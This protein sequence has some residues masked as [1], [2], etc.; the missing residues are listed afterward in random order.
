MDLLFRIASDRA[1]V[2]FHGPRSRED[3]SA[4]GRAAPGCVVVEPLRAGALVEPTFSVGGAADAGPPRLF[5]NTD[6]DVSVVRLDGSGR[7]HLS[8]GDPLVL[9]R[10]R[11]VGPSGDAHGTVNFGSAVGPSRFKVHTEL[12]PEFEFTLKVFP[13]KLDFEDDR[14]RMIEEI[15]RAL[16]AAAMRWAGPTHGWGDLTTSKSTGLER[17]LIV[18][19][20]IPLLERGLAEVTRHPRRAIVR[21]PQP[22]LIHRVKRVDT[23]V[24]RDIRA[25][26]PGAQMEPLPMGA[27]VPRSVHVRTS[28][29]TVDTPEHRWFAQRLRLVA[30][31][32]A[33]LREAEAQ[34]ANANGE[35]AERAKLADGDLGRLA[36]RIDRLRRLEPLAAAGGPPPPG[37]ASLQLMT[38][39]GYGLAYYACMLLDLG[40]RIQNGVVQLAERGMDALYEYW[41]FLKVAAEVSEVA[42]GDP[43]LAPLFRV[44]AKGLAVGLAGGDAS[45]I[46]V[47][48]SA[49]TK[50]TITYQPKFDDPMLTLLGQEPDVLITHEERGWPEQWLVLDAKYRIDSSARHRERVGAPAPPAEALNVLYRYRDALLDG[51]GR[52]GGPATHVVVEAA[53]AYPHYPEPADDFQN[54]R[55]WASLERIGVGGIPLLPG[56]DAWLKEWLRR[57]L[58][59]G[60]WSLAERALAH[61]SAEA[62]QAQLDRLHQ[63]A[64]VCVV[65][66]ETAPARI[67]WHR[68]ALRF[69]LPRAALG[70]AK[71]VRWLAL[72]APAAEG[73]RGVVRWVAPVLH[74]E[75][76]RRGDL[77]TPWAATRDADELGLLFTLGEFRALERPI[78]NPDGERPPT[79]RWSTYLAL[80]H[81]RT[82]GELSIET[83]DEWRLQQR[84]LAEGIDYVVERHTGAAPLG[85]AGGRGGALFTFDDRI[86]VWHIASRGFEMAWGDGR[87]AA[88]LTVDGVVSRLRSRVS[89]VAS[90][91]P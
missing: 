25:S 29:P 55:L 32:L 78:E 60:A 19:H 83:I 71:F 13:T 23:S 88:A 41:V 79:Y 5:E 56:R 7:V 70:P 20:A 42:G 46:R 35:V 77:A 69:F 80:T 26:R 82:L 47:K 18:Q 57:T 31:M 6:Y 3:V 43:D 22:V 2:E 4:Y 16:G 12:G 24:L 39:A 67:D 89:A 49:G 84:L 87:S 27:R 30:G 74:V 91:L 37:F 44:Y 33:R 76:G 48:D 86:R 62:A 45:T 10:I 34:R 14:T 17:A 63:A 81:A 1:A 68:S 53:A 15:Q 85:A 58:G 59:R 73:Q 51:A 38:A 8:H 54:S 21:D 61:R 50:V 11:S 64:L 90:T 72:Y 65:P 9:R 40:L 36:A 28:T 52:A 75:P 66:R